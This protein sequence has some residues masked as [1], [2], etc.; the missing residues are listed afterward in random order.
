MIVSPSKAYFRMSRPTREDLGGG[1][2][3][4]GRGRGGGRREEGRGRGG[5]RGEEGKGT[6]SA[7]HDVAGTETSL[8][9]S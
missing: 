4:E 3:E 8:G 7:L 2:R 1:S 5:G 9:T 6:M